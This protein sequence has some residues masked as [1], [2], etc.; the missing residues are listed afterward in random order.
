MPHHSNRV[1][2]VTRPP[3]TKKKRNILFKYKVLRTVVNFLAKKRE[4][5]VANY[6]DMYVSS[7]KMKEYVFRLSPD[8]ALSTNGP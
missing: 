1:I 4:R 3:E 2:L 6:W 7:G 8:R 5:T